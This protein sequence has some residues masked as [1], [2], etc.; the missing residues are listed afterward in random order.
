MRFCTCSL[1]DLALRGCRFVSPNLFHHTPYNSALWYYLLSE[2]SCFAWFFV[3]ESS[4]LT[5]VYLCGYVSPVH[6]LALV[7]SMVV[8]CNYP[9]ARMRSEGYC[10]WFVCV[11]VCVSPLILALQATR[12]PISDTNGFR[13]TRA[14]KLKGCFSWN[15]CVRERQTGKVADRVAWPNPSLSGAHA[16]RSTWFAV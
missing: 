1:W 6:G 11:C 14:W 9:S 16:S 5:L 12:R 15:D 3:I 2:S 4:E 10:S 13:T 7:C 8:V